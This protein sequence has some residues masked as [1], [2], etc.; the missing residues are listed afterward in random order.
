MVN[1]CGWTSVMRKQSAARYRR[2][3]GSC[4]N[5]A[6][7]RHGALLVRPNEDMAWLAPH[8][9]HPV[10]PPAFS[11]TAIRFCL[12]IKA[13]FRLPLPFVVLL[14]EHGA[15]RAHDGGLVGE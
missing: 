12:S 7:R 8:E 14:E 4:C 1:P 15:D 3:N 13:P 2:R 6:L 10:H 9:G 5:A 11:D